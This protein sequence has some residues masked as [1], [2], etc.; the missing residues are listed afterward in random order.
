MKLTLIFHDG[1]FEN[2]SLD[3]ETI[4]FGCAY[5]AAPR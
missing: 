5:L 2:L 1:A 3:D 4:E